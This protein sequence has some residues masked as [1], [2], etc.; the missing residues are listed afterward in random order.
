MRHIHPSPTNHAHSSCA[1]VS[2]REQPGIAKGTTW[3]PNIRCIPD[4]PCNCNRL[5]KAMQQHNKTLPNLTVAQQPTR[6]RCLCCQGSAACRPRQSM[7]AC[8]AAR[9]ASSH[10]DTLTRTSTSHLP[11]TTALRTAAPHYHAPRQQHALS[12][13]GMPST[14]IP[15]MQTQPELLN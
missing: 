1:M 4:K 7:Q 9:I 2:Q 3:Q 8:W 15:D 13:S 5:P 14:A 6:H 10:P 11:A 12:G